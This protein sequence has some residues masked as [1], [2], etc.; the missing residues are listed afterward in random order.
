LASA[1]LFL[2]P[3]ALQDYHAAISVILPD[4]VRGILGTW[5]ITAVDGLGSA[6]E[7]RVG[8]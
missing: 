8:I 3:S 6:V 5:T 4:F 1:S 7:A 2:A